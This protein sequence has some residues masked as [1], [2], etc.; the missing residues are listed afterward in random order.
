[1]RTIMGAAR[2]PVGFR[3]QKDLLSSPETWMEAICE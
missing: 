2:E 1:M 3:P